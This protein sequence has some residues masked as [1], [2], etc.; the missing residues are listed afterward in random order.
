MKKSTT[1]L[2]LNGIYV[3]RDQSAS[4]SQSSG[5]EASRPAPSTTSTQNVTFAPLPSSAHPPY[6][7]IS[8]PTSNA[9][10]QSASRSPPNLYGNPVNYTSNGVR[11]PP[12]VHVSASSTTSQSPANSINSHSPSPSSHPDINVSPV[13]ASSSGTRPSAADRRS[14]SSRSPVPHHRAHTRTHSP[15]RPQDP[16]MRSPQRMTSSSDATSSYSGNKLTVKDAVVGKTLRSK[17]MEIR[18]QS[19]QM[20]GRDSD[21]T[22]SSCG[23]SYVS[24][25]Q[26]ASER[27]STVASSIASRSYGSRKKIYEPDTS[28]FG[29]GGQLPMRTQRMLEKQKKIEGITRGRHRQRDSEDEDSA[30]DSPSTSP[31]PPI[32]D[33]EESDE[34]D[35][36]RSSKASH[37]VYYV[38]T[39]NG[40]PGS[41]ANPSF[42]NSYLPPG[43]DPRVLESL[44]HMSGGSGFGS[45]A[46]VGGSASSGIDASSSQPT[47]QSTSPSSRPL[48]SGLPSGIT[49]QTLVMAQ[50][51]AALDEQLKAMPEISPPPVDSLGID[52]QTLLMAKQLSALSSQAL[53]GGDIQS[54][55]KQLLAQRGAPPP[56]SNSEIVALQQQIQAL[57]QMLAQHQQQPE[58][59]PSS[60]TLSAPPSAPAP[61]DEE[62]VVP[63]P[64]PVLDDGEPETHSDA[65][66]ADTTSPS[67][68]RP[69]LFPTL[70]RGYSRLDSKP[71]TPPS[72]HSDTGFLSFKPP[73]VMTPEMEEM[74]KEHRA[75]TGKELPPV[76]YR[77][78][79]HRSK[80]RRANELFEADIDMKVLKEKQREEEELLAAEEREPT[81]SMAGSQYEPAV[82]GGL[83]VLESEMGDQLQKRGSK[84]SIDNPLLKSQDDFWLEPDTTDRVKVKRSSRDDLEIERKSSILGLNA[85]YKPVKWKRNTRSSPDSRSDSVS[86]T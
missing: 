18:L 21:Y 57:Q 34:K 38:V 71:P 65:G 56:A 12:N 43:F 50:Q 61:P 66:T 14:S 23:S 37:P 35:D 81:L 79:P 84:F 70:Y 36:T 52:I 7:P 54:L 8:T 39:G 3:G 72:L 19:S 1:P 22:A 67:K 5:H 29:V 58:A 13:R 4:L 33:E 62:E 75:R 51:L 74:A 47:A 44:Q 59:S 45:D 46:D 31:L 10:S 26:D 77:L 24:S 64:A 15:A 6:S 42:H 69:Q 83:A 27:G 9:S 48:P 63:D 68:P 53:D 25:A 60:S 78:V 20:S 30:S 40:Q 85:S 82:N 16:A 76:L 28:T 55:F 73:Q 11:S 49:L 2:G 86:G 80:F 41:N 17:K 32:P